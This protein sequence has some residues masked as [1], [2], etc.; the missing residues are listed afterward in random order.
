[1]AGIKIGAAITRASAPTRRKPRCQ[2]TSTSL[3]LGSPSPDTQCA[4]SRGLGRAHRPNARMV[5]GLRQCVRHPTS[6]QVFGD[7]IMRTGSWG[8]CARRSTVVTCVPDIGA[9]KLSEPERDLGTASTAMP[10]RGFQRDAPQHEAGSG[11]DRTNHFDTECRLREMLR[12]KRLVGELD[13]S[14]G[15]RALE[16]AEWVFNGVTRTG[17]YGRLRQYPAAT[18][19]FLAAEGGRCYDDGTFWPNIESLGDA[20]AQEQSVVGKAFE[21]A[22]RQIGLEDF[23]DAPEAGRW[24]RFV[25]PILLH[26][27]IP[28]S[29]APD[30]AQL[31]LT[32]MRQGVQEGAELID[33]VLRYTTAR[34]AQLDRPLQ[35]FFS[36]GG[37]FA[38]DL[39]ERMMAAVFD[40]NAIG[41]DDAQQLVSELAEELGLPEYLLQALIDGGSIG[42]GV[43][44]RRPPR[45]LVRIDRYSCSGPHVALP[46]VE[47]GGEWLLS[48]SSASRHTALQRE[49]HEVPLTPSRGGWTVTLRSGAVET[50][51]QFK[52]HPDVAAYIFEPGG[53]IAREQRRVRGN[54]ALLLVAKDIEVLCR[55]ETPA[56]LAEELPARGEPWNG[57]KLLSLD[58]S[59]TDALV[60]RSKTA[61][62]ETPVLLPVSQPPQGPAITSLP[63][64]A[65]SGPMG[66]AV[67]ADAPCVAEPDGTTPATWR[68]RWRNDDDTNPPPTAV[69]DDL[70]YGPQGRSLAP[71][72]PTEDSCYGTLE[73]V[74]PLGSDLRERVAVIR[75]LRLTMPD[76]VIGPDE[77][78]DVTVDADC[79]LTDS[80]GSSGR[81]VRIEFEPGCESIKLLAGGVPLTVTIP[82][83]AWVTSYRDMPAAA[84]GRDRQQIGLDQIESG[85]AESLLVRCGRPTS[86]AVELHGHELLQRAEAS[87][88]VG[89]Q[90][91]W[92]FPLSLFRDTASASGLARM[93]L[94]L[95]AE[96]AQA[97]AAVVV[98]RHEVSSLHVDVADAEA[99]EVLIDVAWHEN[100]RFRNRQVRLWPQ[101]RVWEQPVCEDIPDD[102]DG[103]FDCVV[104]APPGP[105]LAEI[106]LR[107]DWTTPQRPSR[108]AASVEVSVGSPQE[109][110]RRLRTLGLTVAA[111]ALE[112]AVS[113]HPRSH[114]IDGAVITAARHELRQ[115]IA[116][117]CSSAVPFD[118]L[119]RLVHL[120]L[121]ADGV[122]EEMLAEE[123]VGA[124][125]SLHMLKLTL[126]MMTAPARCAA[127]AET[128]EALWESEPL[129]AAVL[130]CE[131]DD[132][133]AARWECFAGWVPALDNGGLEQ[134]GE[135]ISRPLDELPPERLTALADALP[136][137]GSLPL[138][139]G[140]Y[141]LA[142]LEMLKKTWPDRTKLNG[143]MAAHTRVFTYT[144]RLA[145]A[146]RQQISA[147]IP[148]GAAGWH[149][150][151]ARL[152]AAAFRLTDD[153]ADQAER[154]AAAQALLD[155]AEIAP[156]LTKRSLF[157]AAALRAASIA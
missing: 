22:V 14:P 12:G 130:D 155:A 120:A 129:A 100:R 123:L 145:L 106:A 92:A 68:V 131:L 44:R 46:P 112:L 91:R 143:W 71:R 59:D 32:D 54:V 69:L 64:A 72:L 124:L 85:E 50:G 105:Y 39:V 110:D 51:A 99:G 108:G 139:F 60:L 128:L 81:S 56:P 94:K 37:E 25:T 125:P 34:M 73:I 55:N 140:G 1:M 29:C 152:Q 13:L 136:P 127:S 31:I 135:P 115:A 88:A 62:L 148:R 41:L 74:G 144:Q 87:Q 111:E 38:L 67:Y 102:V 70:P 16:M 5:G 98:A 27:G 147:L 157:T 141:T 95:H 19:V 65:V 66:C 134:P 151:P 104:E 36:Y 138:Q 35:R 4:R 133:S 48:G 132:R 21:A 18:A 20:S 53:K 82:R 117:S 24:L 118:A 28:A 63:V 61:G 93:S 116:A 126:A 90:G 86:I 17:D 83:L 11:W 3:V 150:F 77:T 7:C 9:C 109:A 153:V 122:L 101:H 96:G 58:L 80:T 79:V 103:S 26:G 119:T 52:G 23:G 76:R 40:I 2:R 8:R 6:A 45:P 154:D 75:G 10:A 113:G 57:W 142:A 84:L 30:A 42:G 149:R 47:G 146:Q 15:G 78:V 114:Q 89:E 49:A 33:G 121:S 43:R 156:L 137:M 107:D 97:D